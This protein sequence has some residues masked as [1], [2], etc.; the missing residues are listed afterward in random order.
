M[1]IESVCLLRRDIFLKVVKSTFKA[2][3]NR[4]AKTYEKRFK[5]KKKNATVQNNI[6]SSYIQKNSN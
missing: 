2:F 5:L 4:L 3:L 6:Q 1:Q